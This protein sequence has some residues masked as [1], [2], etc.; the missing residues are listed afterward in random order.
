MM[1][2]GRRKRAGV[3]KHIFVQLQIDESSMA[4]KKDNFDPLGGFM[5]DPVKPNKKS[6]RTADVLGPSDYGGSNNIY[7]TQGYSDALTDTGKPLPEKKKKRGFFF[8]R[9]EKPVIREEEP[10]SDPGFD[11]SEYK[12]DIK[13]GVVDT[14][15]GERYIDETDVYISD[16]FYD[17][18]ESRAHDFEN[19]DGLFESDTPAPKTEIEDPRQPEAMP[20]TKYETEYEAKPQAEVEFVFEEEPV[21]DKPS[22]HSDDIIISNEDIQNPLV[23]KHEP[24]SLNPNVCYICGDRSFDALPQFGFGDGS[25]ADDFVPLCKTCLH[26]VT[27]LMKYRDP[28]DEAEIIEEWRILCPNISRLRME[29]I[30]REGRKNH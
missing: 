15:I 21:I 16:K 14:G 6:K 29:K 26:A 23:Q 30:V 13:G 20:E 24:V 10:V 3:I 9:K 28:N 5:S 11:S 2:F 25:N 7:D 22:M 27:T 1:L 17:R 8:G 19:D 12:I 4:R 18:E